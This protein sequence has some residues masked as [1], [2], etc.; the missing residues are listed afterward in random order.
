MRSCA[1]F[2]LRYADDCLMAFDSKADLQAAKWRM[3][4]LWWYFY[5]MRAKR[6]GVKIVD[7]DKNG[8]DFCGY[9]LHR[10]TEKT[11]TD[12]DKGY[13]TVRR[14]IILRAQHATRRN[15]P[16]YF[17]QLRHADTFRKMTTIEQAMKLQQ[18][19]QKV[20][21]DREMDAKQI[22]MRAVEQRRSSAL[23]TTIIP[24][25]SSPSSSMV[26]TR[27]SSGGCVH[28]KKYILIKSSYLSRMRA[29]RTS[30]DISLRV[31]AIRW[32]L[33]KVANYVSK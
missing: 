20:R 4:N 16:C 6:H 29:L 15:W 33:F 7:I 19:T 27:A 18:L 24:A 23:Q 28:S 2:A 3:Y 30:A 31:Q 11:V 14:S 13:T 1:P 9:I 25:R 5:R 26:T 8:L 17:G 10:N 21:I 32:N 12:H 22:D